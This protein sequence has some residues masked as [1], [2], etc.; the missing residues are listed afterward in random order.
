MFKSKKLVHP[1]LSKTN[2]TD[3]FTDKNAEF[4]IGEMQSVQCLTIS[5]DFDFHAIARTLSRCPP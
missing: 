4:L 3:Y 2:I 1:L 5:P